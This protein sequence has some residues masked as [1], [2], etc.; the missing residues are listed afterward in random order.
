M[1]SFK[2][3]NVNIPTKK[4]NLKLFSRINQHVNFVNM[5]KTFSEHFV[6]IVYVIISDKVISETVAV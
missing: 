1:V 5:H 2:I 3:K 6:N 4:Q